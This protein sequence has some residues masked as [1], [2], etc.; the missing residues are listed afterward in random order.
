MQLIIRKLNIEMGLTLS[1]INLIHSI[2]S[3]KKWEHLSGEEW[4]FNTFCSFLENFDCE[5]R[6]LLISL[7]E[8]FLVVPGSDYVSLF[9]RALEQY[10][11]TTNK[12]QRI[13]LC[14]LLPEQDF[15]KQKS[16]CSLYYDIKALLR[17]IQ[18][19][20]KKR[21][22]IFIIDNPK[23]VIINLDKIKDYKI[24]LVDDFIGTGETAISGVDYF[25]NNGIS[26]DKIMIISLVSMSEGI[27]CLHKNNIEVYSAIEM[28]KAITG[29]PNENKNRQIML[30]I[31]KKIKTM[32]EYSFGYGQSEALVKVKRTPNNTFP[33]FWETKHNKFAP[34]PR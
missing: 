29:C 25:T 34:F 27:S 23:E 4:Y 32:P 17:F 24:C 26:K 6:K 9:L 22:S 10:L 14:P 20:Y 5:E 15:G 16:S 19:E 13:V 28:D 7:T 12:K 33:V 30:K 11:K 8:K 31:E 1:E 2:L 18:T 3:R 21:V